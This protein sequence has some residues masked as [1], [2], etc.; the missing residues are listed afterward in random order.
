MVVFSSRPDLHHVS[1]AVVS[2]C[3]IFFF[4]LFLSL[5]TITNFNRQMQ[6]PYMNVANQSTLHLLLAH[7]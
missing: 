2:A 4:L 5:K 3:W 6:K 7:H 1:I